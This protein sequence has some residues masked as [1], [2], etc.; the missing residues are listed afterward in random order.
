ML[1]IL[2]INNAKPEI[3]EFVKP[4]EKIITATGS[5]FI[6]INYSET[7]EFNFE[8]VDGA[9]LTGSPQGDD[10]IEHHAP[11]F[12]WIKTFEKPILGIC[13]GH[14][15]TG[16]LYGSEILRGKEPECHDRNA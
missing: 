5:T 1:K 12:Q 13:A 8:K 11:Y 14:H 3:L 16:F 6:T 4:I 10:I 2:I 9:V 15:I 7:L